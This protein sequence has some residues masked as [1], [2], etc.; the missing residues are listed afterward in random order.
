M[1]DLGCMR[2]IPRL[3]LNAILCHVCLIWSIQCDLMHE[4]AWIA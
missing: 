3:V 2:M 1:I 4:S